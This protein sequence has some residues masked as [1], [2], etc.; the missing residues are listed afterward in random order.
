MRILVRCYEIGTQKISAVIEKQYLG[1]A[2]SMVKC[3]SRHVQKNSTECVSPDEKML[4]MEDS[5]GCLND[6]SLE[7]GKKGQ[8]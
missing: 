7:G 1:R 4:E 2:H 5:M 8:S 6:F 3:L